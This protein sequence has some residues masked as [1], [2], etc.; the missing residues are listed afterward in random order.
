MKV[1]EILKAARER[2]KIEALNAMQQ[3][4]WQSRAERM[5]VLSPT[6]SGKTVAF[7]GA[8]LQRLSGGEHQLPAALVLAPSRELVIQIGEVLRSLAR[9]LKVA[10]FYGRHAMADEVNT[11]TGHPDIIVATPGRL[12]DHLTRKSVD[13]SA[14]EALVI[15]EYDKSLELGFYDEMSRICRRLPRKLRLVVLTSATAID[16]MPDFLDL[17]AAHTIDF[18]NSGKPAA[19]L[20]VA[21]VVSYERDKLPV[22]RALLASVGEGRSMVF[23]NHRESAE[24]VHQF[25]VSEGF[26]TCLYHGGLEQQD[27]D[28]AVITLNNGTT[29][30]MVATDLAA[31]GLDIEAVEN[32]IHYHL[33][34]TPQALTHRNGRTARVDRSGRVY[35]IIAEGENVP[36]YVD[37]DHDF[38]PDH[39]ASLPA[40]PQMVTYYANAGRKEKVSR[41]DLVGLLCKTLGLQGAQI[42]RI[43]VRDH[44]AYVA[45]A[46]ETAPLIPATTQK[47]K[48]ARLRLT[49]LK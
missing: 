17:S 46:A 40:Q 36:E 29:P 34:P 5:V 39:G 37:W 43:D 26:A 27:R 8:M 2:L 23:V 9:G 30:V 42:G 41:G 7:A 35:F 20:D 49:P 16:Q 47:I 22:L 33:P 32:V 28:R 11:L 48:S 13:L 44:S 10:T 45:I 21:R 4:V 6:G 38:H 19:R 18:S 15:D 1:G 3:T 31:R 24:R 12:L 25:L 14:L